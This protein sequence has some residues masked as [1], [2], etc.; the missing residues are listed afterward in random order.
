MQWC[1]VSANWIISEVWYTHGH[2]E[3]MIVASA[4]IT[5]LCS[6]LYPNESWLSVEVHP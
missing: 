5:Q 4:T 3:L 2:D 1:A 6:L